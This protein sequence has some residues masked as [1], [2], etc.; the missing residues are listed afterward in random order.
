MSEDHR[1][2][3]ILLAEDSPLTRQ[4]EISALKSLG[5]TNILEASDGDQAV[6][7]LEKGEGVDLVI[8][9]WNMPNRGGLEFL[10]WVRQDNRFTYLPFIMATGQGDMAQ[11]QAARDAGVSAFIP[12]PFNAG[13]L[14]EKILVALGD[15]EPAKA[16]GPRVP[17]MTASGKVRLRIAHIQIT[18]HLVLGV[19]KHLIASGAVKPKYFELETLCMGGWNPV[20]QALE[21]GTVDGACVLAPIAMDLFGFGV[22]IRLT[23]FAHRNGS[24]MVRSKQGDYH[25]PW[26]EFFA[27]RSFLIPH[28][29]SIHHMLTHQFFS[30]MGLSAGMITAGHHYDVNLEVVAPVDMPGFLQANAQTCGF[31]VA[32]PLATKTIASGLTDL[33][34]LSSEMWDNHPCCVL[35]MRQEIL[36][37]P[38][39]KAIGEFH[40]VLV[41]A[42]RFIK[43][44]PENSARIAVDFLD[45]DKKVGLK[46]PVLKNVLTDPMGIR[47]DDLYPVREELDIIQ[48]YMVHDMGIGKLIDLDAFVDT[49]FADIACTGRKARPLARPAF[50]P[51]LVR[52]RT[53]EG[54]DANRT[55]LAREG[56]Y[57]T[58]AL[59]GQEFGLDILKIREIIGMMPIRAIPRAPSHIKGV[60]NL[61]DQVIPVM[62]L[63]LRFGMEAKEYTDRTCIVVLEMETPEKKVFMG[64]VVDSV[65]EV[66][67]IVASQIED[68]S[69][70]GATIQTGYVLGMAKME[71]GVKL[72]LDMENVLDVSA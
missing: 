53:K 24:V 60:I 66:M 47:T 70:F 28:K 16:S 51:E 55:M 43:E 3:R 49:R 71:N 27:G 21:E 6:A 5:Y 8:S 4:I 37:E 18:D 30:G 58:F 40:E 7:L 67:D 44:R 33:Q 14:E 31:M 22:P 12:K 35:A 10:Q 26:K 46:V 11:E 39:A 32:E 68:I 57:L 38:H 17:E 42:G 62:D 48:Q 65:S 19:A 9:D 23:L 34:F 15:V 25:E 54:E 59:Q 20:R 1:K 69:T 2:I 50:S 13:E 29:M 52:S 45:P 36:E 41:A 61:R 72:L 64:V 63:R 56:K